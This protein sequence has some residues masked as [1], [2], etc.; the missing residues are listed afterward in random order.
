MQGFTGKSFDV[1]QIHSTTTIEAKA[2]KSTT[3]KMDFR[4]L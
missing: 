4:D 2:R 1:L 3:Q